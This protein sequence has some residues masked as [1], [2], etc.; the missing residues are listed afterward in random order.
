MTAPRID[1]TEKMLQKLVFCHVLKDQRFSDIMEHMEEICSTFSIWQT[2]SS[3]E[4]DKK[5]RE[6]YDEVRSALHHGSLA[7]KL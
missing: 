7:Q 6:I 2:L 1:K 5:F 4:R 3:D